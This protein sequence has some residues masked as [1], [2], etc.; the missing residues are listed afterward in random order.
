MTAKRRKVAHAEHT[1]Q[2]QLLRE[3]DAGLD[4]LRARP[5]GALVPVRDYNTLVHLDRTVHDTDTDQR[6]VIVL[7]IRLLTDADSGMKDIDREELF[8]DYEQVLF[9][10]VVG[11]AERHGRSV[12]LLVVPST[13]IYDAVAQTAIRLRVREIVLGDSAKMS[14]ADQARLLGEAWDR[15][16]RDTDLSTR[17]V[18]H[19]TSGLQYFS[20]G[21]H[22]PDLS[23][24]DVERI[25]RLWLEAVKAVGPN[26][27]HRDIV[28]AALREFEEELA[29]ARRAD[30][31]VRLRQ[32]VGG[33]RC[34]A[35]GTLQGPEI[36]GKGTPA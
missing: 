28:S 20:L 34:A 26:I 21:A 7:T 12:K 24:E 17:V 1:D 8:T 9:T 18:V 29:G 25:H 14:A 2:F 16:P 11:I 30:A 15:T 22:A 31:V 3:P 4:E 19:S 5:G 10:R 33:A 23:L 6:D 32:Q 35:V 13:N 27:H 36:P